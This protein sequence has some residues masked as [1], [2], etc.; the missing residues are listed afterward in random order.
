MLQIQKRAL[1]GHRTFWVL[2][3]FPRLPGMT[4][5]TNRGPIAGLMEWNRFSR[6]P[7]GD[8]Y[9]KNLR[10]AKPVVTLRIIRRRGRPLPLAKLMYSSGDRH[11]ADRLVA[12]RFS[13]SFDQFLGAL[14]K[15]V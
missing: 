12:N 11:L 5:S 6:N 1:T 7:T 9:R 13:I 2:I 10:R 8:L 4:T 14:G 3:P 15:S